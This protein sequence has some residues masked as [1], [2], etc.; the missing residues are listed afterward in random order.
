MYIL[1]FSPANIFHY[2]SSARTRNPERYPHHPSNTR[3]VPP[4]Y[5]YPRPVPVPPPYPVK[6]PL[7]PASTDSNHKGLPYFT[8]LSF[9]FQYLFTYKFLL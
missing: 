1:F 2:F 9:I 3:T 4:P 6:P 7:F 8:N 5:P